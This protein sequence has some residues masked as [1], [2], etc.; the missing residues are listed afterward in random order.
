MS[1]KST[2]EADKAIRH[3]ADHACLR[4]RCA[5]MDAHACVGQC[6]AKGEQSIGGG[7]GGGMGEEGVLKE[8]V[9]LCAGCEIRGGP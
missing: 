1:L 5:R 2:L 3:C 9:L 8:R 4:P 7:P 6:H